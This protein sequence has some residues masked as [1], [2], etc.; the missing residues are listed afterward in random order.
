MDIQVLAIYISKA[1]PPYY[2]LLWQK[3]D[4]LVKHNVWK[5]QRAGYR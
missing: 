4:T 5:I 1:N 2:E 3:G